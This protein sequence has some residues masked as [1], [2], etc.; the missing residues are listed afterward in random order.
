LQTPAGP[1]CIVEHDLAQ[2]HVLEHRHCLGVIQRTELL[3][4][5]KEVAVGRLVVL[6]LSMQDATLGVNLQQQPDRA[7]TMLDA[8]S[9]LL[10]PYNGSHPANCTVHRVHGCRFTRHKTN[11]PQAA[12]PGTACDVA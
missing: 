5:L 3:K 6:L 12:P 10:A 2:Q 11:E 7:H 8:G 4:G 9:S 1:T